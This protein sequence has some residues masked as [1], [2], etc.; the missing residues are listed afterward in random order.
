MKKKKKKWFNENL[1]INFHSCFL[2]YFLLYG[3]LDQILE[4]KDNLFDRNDVA[5]SMK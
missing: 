3:I 1:S 4:N 2:R 5:P